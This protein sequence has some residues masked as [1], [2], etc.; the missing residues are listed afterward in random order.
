MLIAVTTKFV[1]DMGKV[2]LV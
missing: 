1:P 2:E